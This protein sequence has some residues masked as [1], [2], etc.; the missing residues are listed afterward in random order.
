MSKFARLSRGHTVQLK[1]DE[2]EHVVRN[3]P[4]LSS[5]NMKKLNK[6]Y[7][8][9]K[10]VRISASENELVGSGF[11][12]MVKKGAKAGAKFIKNNKNLNAFKD[13]MIN[14]GLDYAVNK[15]GLDEETG[16]MAKNLGKRLADKGFDEL[17]GGSIFNK[18]LGRKLLKTGAKALKV[19]NKI[20]NAMGYD[21]LQD[22][23]IDTVTNQTIG[24]IDP[25]LGRMAS[26]A[27]QKVADK[28]IDKYAGGSLR[29][30]R[31]GGNMGLEGN[32]LE[33]KVRRTYPKDLSNIVHPG[34]D[35]YL[36][37][38]HNLPMFNQFKQ[39]N[40]VGK[41]FSVH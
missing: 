7:M 24:R 2:I 30:R 37:D 26:N 35:A 8:S 19:G 28:Q 27:L 13:E 33:S 32:L 20:S 5:E 17:A 10:G 25:T 23:A 39:H 36:P 15:I 9:G 38:S 16:K 31:T 4:N 34:S 40:K 41:G 14:D 6:A 21:D 22:M 29:A 11:R 1:P 12:S 3:M 18:Q